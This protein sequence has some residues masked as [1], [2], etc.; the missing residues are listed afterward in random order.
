MKKII[1]VMLAVMMV[2]GLSATAF[3]DG[4]GPKTYEY[5]LYDY[6]QGWWY[7]YDDPVDYYGFD[8]DEMNEVKFAFAETLSKAE[9]LAALYHLIEKLQENNLSLTNYTVIKQKTANHVYFIEVM[10]ANGYVWSCYY[11]AYT[12]DSADKVMSALLGG[13]RVKYYS[14]FLTNY[15]ENQKIKAYDETQMITGFDKTTDDAIAEFIYKMQN[16]D[17]YYPYYY[18]SDYYYDWDYDDSVG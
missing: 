9:G 13:K 5:G 1:S 18:G 11:A 3:A 17:T 15:V 16:F 6:N 8:E 2:L 7:D 10:D 4:Y 12:H 14:I